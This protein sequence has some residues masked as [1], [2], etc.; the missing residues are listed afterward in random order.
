MIMISLISTVLNEEDSIRDFL[1]SILNQS[2]LPDE[3]I[4][5]DGGSKDRT[6]EILKEY[7]KKYSF[8]KVIQERGAN[9]A[10]GRNIAIKNSSGIIIVTADAGCKYDKDYIKEITKPLLKYILSNIEK[11]NIKKDEFLKYLKSKGIDI[12][13]LENIEEG[14]FV[15]GVYYPLYDNKFGKYAGFM[16]VKDPKKQYKVPS[17]TS[18]R[19]TAYFKYIWEEIKGYPENY[20]TGEDT[21][22]HLEILNKKYKWVMNENAKVYWKMPKDIKEFYKKFEKYA[23]GDVLQ[24]NIFKY[25]R[26]LIFFIGFWIL[27]FILI[28]SLILNFKLFI[29]IISLIILYLLYLAVRYYI[30]TKDPLTIIYIPILELTRRLAYQIGFIKGLYK[31]LL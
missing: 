25:K 5:V 9:I 29:F 11:F 21:R 15:Q 22:F 24:G 17:R 8:I 2:L 30:K 28:L 23:I 3:I 19:A 4:I 10:R 12:K 14:E 31:K 13:E 20:V 7:E 18:A 1:E 26:L 16:L 27:I 6:Y